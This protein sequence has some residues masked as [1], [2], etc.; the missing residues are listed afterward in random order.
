[1]NEWDSSIDSGPFNRPANK[2]QSSAFWPSRQPA[3]LLR[4]CWMK[5][6]TR[7]S[8]GGR[9]RAPTRFIISL[10]KTIIERDRERRVK[11]KCSSGLVAATGVFAW[12]SGIFQP[13]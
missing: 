5:N 4:C 12:L 9:K 13:A 6:D 1:M 10:K 8:R 2:C 3:L 7:D 11:K